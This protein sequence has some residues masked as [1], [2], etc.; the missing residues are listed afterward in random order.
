MSKSIKLVLSGSGTR[1]PCFI[2]AIRALLEEGYEIEELCGTS[3]GAFIASGFASFYNFKNPLAT[4]DRLESM[5]MELLPK[6]LID[7]NFLPFMRKGFIGGR[8]IFN[9]L[10]K[11]LPESFE[12]TILP[13]R[14]VTFNNSIARHHVWSSDAEGVT[15][16]MCVRAS[17][18]LPVIFD[19][20]NLQ[21]DY[22]SDGGIVGNFKLD[23]FGHE[24]DNVFGIAFSELEKPKRRKIL[25][26][27]DIIKAHI[28]G[29][30]ETTSLEDIQDMNGTPVCYIKTRH[31]GLNL[32]MTKED[33]LDQIN[34]G[35]ISMKKKLAS[36]T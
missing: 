23:V 11:E 16:P 33:V 22:H 9:L 19:L 12:G 36:M 8:K 30:I 6:P 24:A 10:K 1:Y 3:G 18:S 28:D 7:F 32:K 20:V 2:G 17:M 29:V 34:D 25:F 14:V 5:A 4:V 21:G 31:E 27:R 26:K 15:L 35:Y 13:L